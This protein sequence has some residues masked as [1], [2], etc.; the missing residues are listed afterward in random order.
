MHPIERRYGPRPTPDETTYTTAADGWRLALHHYKPRGEK[1]HGEPVLLQHGLG[2]CA[3]QFDLGVGTPELPTPSLAHWL[4]DQGYDV[5]AGDLRGSGAS[6]RPGENQ[7]RRWDWSLD[8]FIAKDSPAF[9]DFILAQSR[10]DAL[11]WVGHSMGGILMLCHAALHG[12]PRIASGVV[13]AAGLDYSASGSSYDL[14]EPLKNLGRLVK[15][16]P[17][18]TFGK[19][20]APFF[21]RVTNPMEAS[22][23]HARNF[24][25]MGA[26]AILAGA[27]YD[28]SGEVLYQLAT[29]F[30]KGGLQ[31]LDGKTRFADIA[32]QVQTPT[33][34][35]S[36]EK[37]LQ[38]STEVVHKTHAM[39]G[40]DQHATRAF[41]KSH[42]QP[43]HYGHFDLFG[44]VRA[45]Q[46]VFP[47]VL[48]WLQAHPAKS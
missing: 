6:Q 7:A 11:H 30:Q 32:H 42:G 5:W 17:A 48:D 13:A 18:G 34:F 4:A 26:R 12:S 27:N 31:S 9:I 2:T 20:L 19:Y 38:C 24:S 43:E 16:V 21:G 35:I 14:I 40:G 22:F 25:P 8:D 37:D 39:L 3:R 45:D 33:L 44:G 23:F 28:L 47:H 1:P 41:G 15:W 46:E 29:L 10:Y 36:G